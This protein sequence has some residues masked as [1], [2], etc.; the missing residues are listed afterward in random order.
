MNLL[1]QIFRFYYQG[2]ASM[3]V[4]K[5]LWLII[6]LKLFLIFVVI[7]LL[8]FPNFLNKKGESEKEK[9]DYVLQQL[10]KNK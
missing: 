8:F 6:L 7:K 3:E 4:G 1:K 2:F 9:A 10:T 5:K